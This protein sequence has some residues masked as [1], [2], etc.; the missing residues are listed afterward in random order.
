ML[1]RGLPLCNFSLAAHCT[2]R[3]L[4]LVCFSCAALMRYVQAFL[5]ACAA[6]VAI[7][8]LGSRLPSSLPH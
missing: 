8:P 3:V 7:L 2:P 6:P 4:L 1:A 5:E